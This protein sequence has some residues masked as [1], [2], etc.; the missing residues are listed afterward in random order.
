[1]YAYYIGV[2]RI[3]LRTGENIFLSLRSLYFYRIL[4]QAEICKQSRTEDSNFANN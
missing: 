3:F 4:L 2:L 1:M